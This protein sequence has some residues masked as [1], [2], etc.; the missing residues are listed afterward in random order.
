[1]Q[2]DVLIGTYTHRDAEGIYRGRFDDETGTFETLE[3]VVAV[4]NPAFLALRD[5]MLFAVNEQMDGGVSAFRRDGM[6]LDL[7]GAEPS[8][9]SLPC[10]I[11]AGAGWVAVAN[12]GSGSVTVFPTVDGRLQPM[13]DLRQHKGAG[14][15][16]ARQASAHPHEVQQI[17]ESALLVPD[18]GTDHLH[19]YDVAGHRLRER[20]AIALEPG[21]GP[22][23]TKRH[24]S[25][26]VLYVL[27][28][29]GNTVDVLTW[30]D[31]EPIQRIDT[32]PAGFEGESTTA[33][34]VVAP[35]GGF[36]HASNRGHDSIVTFAVDESGCLSAPSFVPTLGQHPRYFC[37]DPSGGWLLVLNQDSDNAVVYR[38]DGGR[39]IDVVCKAQAPTPVCLLWDDRQK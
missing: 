36:V 34:I 19:I 5:G 17:G 2:H 15:N 32:L 39:P 13:S 7:V 18:L 33:E 27:G 38:I 8:G 24:P 6:G 28:E 21:S 25:N 30:P 11:S 1:M 12:Y 26:P 20:R 35:D 3:L 4:A 14:P 16:A 37:L 22:R 9:G 29:L 31:L 23:H 10:H